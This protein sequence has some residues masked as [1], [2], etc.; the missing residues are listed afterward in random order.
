MVELDELPKLKFKGYMKI[1]K[2]LNIPS[3]TAGSLIPSL[4]MCCTRKPLRVLKKKH[5]IIINLNRATEKNLQCTYG[6]R[7]GASCRMPL[8]TKK[9][10]KEF[11]KNVLW[12]DVTKL[13]LLDPWISGMSGAKKAGE[14][15]L[16]GQTWRRTSPV[17]GV[18]YC[19]RK[20]KS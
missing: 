8:L 17:M 4:K 2:T 13:E 12:S 20:W 10:I 15:H 5:N 7:V 1:S 16:H 6:L 9:N 19:Y 3:D 14:H 11:W 18:F